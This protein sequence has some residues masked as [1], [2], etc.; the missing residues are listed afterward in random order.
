MASRELGAEEMTT[1]AYNLGNIGLASKFLR[2]KDL[3]K[4]AV[5]VPPVSGIAIRLLASGFR[6]VESGRELLEVR[7]YILPIWTVEISQ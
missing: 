4:A 3:M 2:T 7:S 1:S 5:E 6:F